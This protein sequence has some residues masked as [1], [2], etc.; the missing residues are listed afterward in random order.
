MPAAREADRQRLERMYSLSDYDYHLPIKHIAQTPAD[1]RDRS[2]LLRLCRKTGRTH[3]HRF[4][5]L[6]HLLAPGDVLVVNNTEVIP[7]RLFGRKETG[8]RVEVLLLNYPQARPDDATGRMTGRCLIRASRRPG[9]GTRIRLGDAA[10][11]TVTGFDKG[12]FDIDLSFDGDMDAILNRIGHIPLPPY[13]QRNGDAPPCDDARAYQTVF[14]REKGAVA[15][16]TAGLHFTPDLLNQL[17]S[18]GV[19]IVTITLHVGYGTFSPVRV[20]DIRDHQI[21]TEAYRISTPAARTINAARAA[22]HRIIAVGTTSCRTLEYAARPAGGVA[23]GRGM[24]DLFIY[25][26]YRFKVVDALITNF[27]LPQSTLL[28]LVSALAGREKILAAYRAAIEQGYR[29]FS[30]GDAMFI[31]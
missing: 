19:Q 5:D 21:H 8:G 22:G 1:R 24:C 17:K 31:E 29:F 3:H 6:V 23:P 9:V 10:T 18:A 30:Y 28:M 7:A 13:I 11:A 2:R 25:P 4:D 12:V 26:G 14:A 16:P 15:A 27:H 20:D